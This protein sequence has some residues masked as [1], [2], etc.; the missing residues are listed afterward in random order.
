MG[1]PLHNRRLSSSRSAMPAQLAI[2]LGSYGTAGRKA[3]NQD[4]HGAVVPH[5]GM[6]TTKGIAIALADGISSSKLGAVAAETAVKSFLNDYFATSEAWSVQTSAQCVISATNS[7]MHAQNMAGRRSLTDEE[8]DGGLICT[9]SALVLKSRTAHLFHVGDSRIARLQGRS[10][11]VLTEAHRIDL[12][13][14]ESYLARALGANRHVEIDYLRVGLEPEDLFIL[15]SDG[16]HEYLGDAEIAALIAGQDDLEA[17]AQAIADAA[18]DAGSPDNLTVQLVRVASLPDGG[19]A[20]L[21]A[22]DAG[23]PP[24]PMLEPGMIFEGHAILRVL[25][26]G[27]RSHVYLARDL[28]GDGADEAMVAIKVP[29]T[30]HAGD[31]A[32]MQALML[33]EWIARRVSNPH[34]LNAPP[35]RA[36]RRFAYVVTHY[37][38][39]EPL[40][41]W[42]RDHRNPDL[43]LFRDVMKQIASGLQALHRR[44]ILHRDLRPGNILVDA[45]GIVRIIDFGSAQVAGLDE[46][47]PPLIEAAHAGTMQYGAPEL[48][49]GHEATRRSD[50]YSLGVIAYQ[51]LTGALPYGPRV[52]AANSPAAQR[53][54]RYVP[55]RDLNWD[56]PEWLDAAIAKAVKIDPAERYEE[57]SE[58]VYDIEHPNAAL[59]APDPRPLLQRRPERLWQAISAVL[60]AVILVLL[61]REGHFAPDV[62]SHSGRP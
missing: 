52:A 2:D 46:V 55:A 48:Y 35:V 4:F 8:R 27:S 45:F 22:N 56:V 32:Q 39:G 61:W 23:L 49:L 29:A 58:F 7:W 18:L 19:I 30:D 14:G 11:E 38:E 31:D 34:V 17:A 21:L 47:R 53:K 15:T 54:L 9:F 16:V 37:V 5:G 6:L 1:E 51:M 28:S 43:A 42:M 36:A 20:E 57:L 41:Q 60:F 59:V 50:I 62:V 40:D 13:G 12:G 3:E 10:F 33:E 44:E 25:H 26:S 24:A